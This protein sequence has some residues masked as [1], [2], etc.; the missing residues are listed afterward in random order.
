M[1][2]NQ[3]NSDVKAQR[4]S[5]LFPLVSNIILVAATAAFVWIMHVSA[6]EQIR[7]VALR[8][9]RFLTTEWQ[10]LKELKAQTDR[11]LREKEQE[12]IALR[13]QYAELKRSGQSSDKL[14][15]LEKQL[16]SAEDER[17][18]IIS[19][20]MDNM[21]AP[22]PEA[23]EPRTEQTAP[24]LPSPNRQLVQKIENLET[25]NRELQQEY[26][27]LRDTLESALRHIMEKEQLA[28]D[29]AALRMEDLSTQALLRALISSPRV[30]AQYPDLLQSTDRYL[31]RLGLQERYSGRREAYTEA[32]NLLEEIIVR[33][34]E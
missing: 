28:A 17:D 4:K 6:E 11:Q 2:A 34:E 25:Q 8:E 16:L 30:R 14:L 7:T 5:L 18:R 31:S 20:R 9:S 26:R 24:D 15:E 10:L 27:D 12:I 32:K 21:A 33:T 19:R 13:Q 29:S 23:V 3:K 1:Q 22:V